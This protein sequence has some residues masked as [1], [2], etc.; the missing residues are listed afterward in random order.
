M[1]WKPQESPNW[2]SNSRDWELVW[3]SQ[4][5]K[6]ASGLLRIRPWWSVDENLRSQHM[7]RTKSSCFFLIKGR[8]AFC[9]SCRSMGAHGDARAIHICF[10]TNL[11]SATPGDKV[12]CKVQPWKRKSPSSGSVLDAASM[13]RVNSLKSAPKATCKASVHSSLNLT[14][15]RHGP[16][17]DFASSSKWHRA[18]GPRRTSLTFQSWARAFHSCLLCHRLEA[19]CLALDGFE[20]FSGLVVA[21]LDRT[22]SDSDLG[23][24]TSGFAFLRGRSK[25]RCAT[26][27]TVWSRGN[28]SLGFLAARDVSVWRA[29]SNPYSKLVASRCW[30]WFFF[31]CSAF[32]LVLFLCLL[33]WHSQFGFQ[34]VL[35]TAEVN[36]ANLQEA[37]VLFFFWPW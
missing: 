3:D 12:F 27:T 29:W 9:A 36:F 20:T 24:M 26:S 16:G 23:A 19:G 32:F 1:C 5:R 7:R 8:F 25:P 6:Q 28:N 33:L 31:F 37:V 11:L 10:C 21:G 35:R 4:V 13:T 17:G 34:A 2:S 14:W 30:F 18:S 15:Q 22:A